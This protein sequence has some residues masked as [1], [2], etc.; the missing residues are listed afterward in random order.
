ML[1]L[2]S[3]STKHRGLMERLDPRVRHR[4][5]CSLHT[6]GNS[7]EDKTPRARRGPQCSL[8]TVKSWPKSPQKWFSLLHTLTSHFPSYMAVMLLSVSVPMLKSDGFHLKSGATGSVIL[9]LCDLSLPSIHR[10]L[11]SMK[12]V[13]IFRDRISL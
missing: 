4:A 2:G 8:H 7:C 11:W 13:L 9:H 10:R 6:A 5:Q 1:L 12:S 3:A